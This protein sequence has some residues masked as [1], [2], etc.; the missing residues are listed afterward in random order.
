LC[1][2]ATSC[3]TANPNYLGPAPLDVIAAQI[4]ISRGPSGDNFEYLF[5]LADAMRAIPGA[6]DEELFILETLVK[7]KLAAGRERPLL[8]EERKNDNAGGTIEETLP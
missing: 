6:I 2:I 4:A 7:N 3:S 5:K 1:Y 8:P